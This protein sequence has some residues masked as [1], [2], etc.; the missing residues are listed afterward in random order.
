MD[1]GLSSNKS[2]TKT[3]ELSLFGGADNNSY[4]SANRATQ[5]GGR[6]T[7]EKIFSPYSVEF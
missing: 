6:L 1:S 5:A 2:M 7:F 4:S 3:P